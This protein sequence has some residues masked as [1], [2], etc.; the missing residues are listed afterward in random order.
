MSMYMADLPPVLSSSPALSSMS[1]Y[2]ADLPPVLSSSPALSSMSMY[3]ADLPH[4]FT[5]S[6]ALSSMSMYMADLPPVLSSSPALSSISMYMADLP[7]VLSSSPALSSMSMYIADLP[8]V[9]SSS[10]ALSSMSMYMADLPP[11]LSSSPALSSMSMYIADLPP[12]L[13]SSPALSSMSMYMA[14]L[15]PILSSF[16]ALSSMSMY[17]ADLP[18]AG[19]LLAE[20]DVITDS[21]V[22]L[23]S[24]YTYSDAEELVLNCVCAL[25][26][27]S[28]YNSHTNKI[29]SV[30]P[31]KLLQHVTP[32]LMCENEEAMVE[33]ARTYGNFSR[34]ARAREYMEKARVLE[35]LILLLDHSSSELLY[36]VCGTLINFTADAARKG[37]L[38]GLGCVKRLMEVGII[39]VAL[40]ALFNIC[41]DDGP[42]STENADVP[43][44]SKDEASALLDCLLRVR[45]AAPA[46]VKSC[47][48]GAEIVALCERLEVVEG[49]W[50]H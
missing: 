32:L 15:P 43:S 42:A 1:M 3:M 10:P 35:A 34:V 25:T 46:M 20:N 9:L 33:A 19:P 6:P 29:L 16:P 2:I 13:S 38:V 31:E 14:D 47:A 27:L 11:V 49:R 12:V 36:S 5:S 50:N 39:S 24:S 41:A 26:N 22:K 23:L 45:G 21:L 17:M 44:V 28:F 4:V 37:A 7:P 8:P 48:E 18:H 40:K 30:E